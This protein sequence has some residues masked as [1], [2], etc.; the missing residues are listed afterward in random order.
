MKPNPSN[1]NVEI[2]F[3][4]GLNEISVLQLIDITGKTIYAT[5]IP[6][7]S[8]NKQIQCDFLAKGVYQICVF[9]STSISSKRLIIN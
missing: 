4:G 9:N 5:E 1:G 2:S 7:G 8:I 6:K 3:D